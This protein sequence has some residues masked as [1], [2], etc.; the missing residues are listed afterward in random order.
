[1]SNAGHTRV[2]AETSEDGKE[3]HNMRETAGPESGL[4]KSEKQGAPSRGWRFWAIFPPICLAT[5][6]IALESTVTTASLPKIAADLDAGD[7]YVWIMNGYLL[8]A[9]V[10]VYMLLVLHYLQT[11]CSTVFIPFFGQF[12]FVFGRRWP[13]LFAVVM[14]MLGSGVAGGADSMAMLIGMSTL[15]PS[16]ASQHLP[17]IK[18]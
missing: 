15:S 14:F 4:P 6:L 1:M 3:S 16:Y 2:P 17:G 8:T 13:T 11:L 18:G 12:A 10:T 5:L 9:S 7:N